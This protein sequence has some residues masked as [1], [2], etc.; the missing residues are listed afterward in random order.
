MYSIRR[1]GSMERRAALSD[2]TTDRR[3]DC[4][5]QRRV[6]A[7]F[8]P[9]GFRLIEALLA[10][11][12][13]QSLRFFT[14]ELLREAITLAIL[15]KTSTGPL[16]ALAITELI[17]SSTMP[18]WKPFFKRRSRSLPFFPA[19]NKEEEG[20]IKKGV[21]VFRAISRYKCTRIGVF[22]AGRTAFHSVGTQD[23][24]E[25]ETEGGNVLFDL[26]DVVLGYTHFFALL[27]LGRH[28]ISIK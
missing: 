17:K 4:C 6:L 3:R 27:L 23:I 16:S 25:L 13:F 28:F 7:S 11:T 5:D 19:A 2:S 18:I 9:I 22:A 24:D 20:F 21:D 8:D 10:A 14:L 1:L 15:P 12:A 26:I